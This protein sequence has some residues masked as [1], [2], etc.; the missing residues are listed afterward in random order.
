MGS[1][2]RRGN[3]VVV[4]LVG[5]RGECHAA[6]PHP[7]DPHPGGLGQR[8]RASEVGALCVLDR[9]RGLG[10]L[11]DQVASNWANVAMTFATMAPA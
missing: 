1:T 4:Q 11:A 5:D 10:A 7:L 3:S 8:P 9:K 6:T 2:M